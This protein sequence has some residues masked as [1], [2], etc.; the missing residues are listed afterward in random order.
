MT[1]ARF[2]L[3]R[4]ASLTG[5]ACLVWS[6]CLLGTGCSGPPAITWYAPP[7]PAAE[8]EPTLDRPAVLVDPFRVAPAYDSARITYREGEAVLGRYSAREWAAL[9]GQLL[10]SVTAEALGA[11]FRRVG[12]FEAPLDPDVRVGGYVRV[13]EVDVRG[14]P[15]EAVLEIVFE[16]RPRAGPMRVLTR[17]VTATGADVAAAVAGLGPAYAAELSALAELIRRVDDDDRD[18]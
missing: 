2:A 17:R 7:L 15:L 10:A 8:G 3:S 4:A 18:P 13:L 1:R 5:A 14:A 9:P 11:H 6:T 16:V 12:Y